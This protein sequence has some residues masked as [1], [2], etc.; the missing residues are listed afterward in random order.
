MAFVVLGALTFA[1]A[2]RADDEPATAELLYVASGDAAARCPDE[3]SFR[4]Q[5]AGRL[6][7]QPFTPPG[8]H[9]VAVTLHAELG[10]VRGRAEVTRPGKKAPRIRELDDKIGQ[11]EALVAALAT[12]VAIAVDSVRGLRP[13][14]AAPST[15]AP[16]A[17]L[18]PREERADAA[19]VA[20][21]SPP[22][23]RL[24]PPP[25]PI[26]F[27]A[28]T[29]G[30]F[31]LGDAPGTSVGAEAGFGI[32]RADLSVELSARIETMPEV[33]RV[34]SGDRL[35]A[36]I[37]SGTLAPCG[38]LGLFLGCVFGRVGAFQGRA[39]DVVDPSLGTSVFGAVGLRAG[40]RFP[41]WS[42]IAMQAM[43]E[44]GL[45]LV[46]TSLLVGRTTVW[47][48]PPGFGGGGLSLVVLFP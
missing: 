41:L 38:Q 13:A 9:R 26:L 46:R 11:C 48:A 43:T 21:P 5:V 36:T 47:T 19:A 22:P 20:P 40:V 35:E 7:Y 30:V 8:K 37:L 18:S 32:R 31:S 15:P 44:A 27:F 1:T 23:E 42:W 12:T 28:S 45:P 6:E 2:A 14:P 10:R 16:V 17:T 25:P 3:E 29:G 33:V 39:S 24:R 4:N 34:R